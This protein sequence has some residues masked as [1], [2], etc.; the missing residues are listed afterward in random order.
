MGEAPTLP[1][2]GRQA[3]HYYGAQGLTDYEKIEI[4]NYQDVYFLG[5]TA[6]KIKGSTANSHNFGYDDDR[7]D[8]QVVV[9]DH[10]GF[11][12]EV[13][14][15]LGSG[16]FGQA[17]KCFD[18]KEQQMVAIKVIRNKKRFQY[19]A[20]VELRILK[21]LKDRDKDDDN[22][23]IRIIDYEIFRRH[24]LIS[25]ELLSMNLYEFIKSNNFV[26][27]SIGLIRRFAI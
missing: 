5:L 8:Y 14:D 19:Q 15:K 7:G 27:V 1:M 9:K 22:N 3:A 10:L 17:L 26:G 6:P 4:R 2:A 25:F 20:G 21:Y 12:Y 11:R 23:I 16:S 24:L 18:H 13:L